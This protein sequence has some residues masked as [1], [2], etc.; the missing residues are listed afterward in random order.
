M[1][2]KITTANRVECPAGSW[3]ARR[4]SCATLRKGFA[5]S[6]SLRCGAFL[7]ILFFLFG[8]IS[9]WET[10]AIGIIST[11]IPGDSVVSEI[12][13]YYELDEKYSNSSD[14]EEIDQWWEEKIES[15]KKSGIQNDIY[16][17]RGGGPNGAQWN[18]FTDLYFVV[19]FPT[20]LE[21]NNIPD[22]DYTY[23]PISIML[24]EKPITYKLVRRQSYEKG[25]ML[26]FMIEKEVWTYALRP[27]EPHDYIPLFGKERV[28]SGED[29]GAFS[30]PM[31]TGMVFQIVVEIELENKERMTASKYFHIA[32]GE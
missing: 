10:G 22:D 4:A 12:G 30:A 31:N 13:C 25:I 14:Q 6:G 3:S 9:F 15:I 29:G 24:N 16:S 11:K 17:R 32:Y 28:E 8:P 1:E 26:D 18:T 5:Y 19:L 2:T 20:K 23:D 7:T 27:V 21:L